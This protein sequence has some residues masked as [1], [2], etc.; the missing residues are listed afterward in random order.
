MQVRRSWICFRRPLSWARKHLTSTGGLSKPRDDPNASQEILDLP[1]EA[2]FLGTE[3]PDKHRGAEA[4]S[5]FAHLQ[6]DAGGAPLSKE[7][8]AGHQGPARA[9]E[10]CFLPR[11]EGTCWALDTHPLPA[12]D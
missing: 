7:A 11:C 9:E 10:G 2:P 4:S 1:Q 3:A 8:E 5:V 12:P 6:P